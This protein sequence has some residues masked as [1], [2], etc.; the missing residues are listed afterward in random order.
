MPDAVATA[1]LPA[2]SHRWRA[3]ERAD[4]AADARAG[5]ELDADSA[6]EAVDDAEDVPRD[7]AGDAIVDP[8]DACVLHYA[9]LGIEAFGHKYAL[10][11]LETLNTLPFHVAAVAAANGVRAARAPPRAGVA[12]DEAAELLRDLYRRTVLLDDE[13]ETARQLHHGVCFA[14]EGIAA[15]ITLG[16]EPALGV[17]VAA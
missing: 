10:R 17:S 7:E 13:A 5:D 12:D 1:A 16:H 2:G 14:V 15:I 9:N 6:D 4:E 8:Q 11:R 3:S